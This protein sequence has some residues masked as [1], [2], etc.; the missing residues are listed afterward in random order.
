[1]MKK[2]PELLCPAGSLKS[3]RYAFAY[4][5]DAVYAGQSRY[6]LRVKNNEFN[7]LNLPKAIDYAHDLGKQFFLVSNILPHNNKVKTFID[8]ISPIIEAGPDALIMSDPGL[9]AMVRERWPEQAIH[10]SVQSNVVNFASVKFWQQVG[11]T[12]IILS[13]E[14]SIREISEI[15]EA[16]PDIELEV[17]VHGALCMAYS[18]RCLLSGYMNNRDA[19]QGSCSNA[20]RWKY[21][22]KDASLNEMGDVVLL[23]EPRHSE[24]PIEL[25][26]DEHGTYMLNSKDLRAIHFIDELTKMGV[27]CFKIEGRTKSHFYTSRTAQLYRQAIDDAVAGKPFNQELFFALDSLANRGFTEGFFAQHRPEDHQNYEYGSS[28]VSKQQ[29]CAEVIDYDRAKERLTVDVKNHFEVGDTLELMLPSGN[30]V[31]KLEAMENK[32]GQSVDVAPG[33]GHVM[34]L[35]FSEDVNTEFGL[36]MKQL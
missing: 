16:C 29:F 35:P 13:R 7:H 25:H 1:M 14:M 30:R 34:Q 8:E 15:R 3:M 28:R 31:F 12:R 2:A 11:V 36:L 17:F 22:T 5:A 21:K 20:C 4:G 18:G 19:N 9:I 27:D 10:L 23:E 33:S 32:D 6:S 24:D 26:E